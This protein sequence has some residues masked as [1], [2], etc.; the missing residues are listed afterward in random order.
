M[1]SYILPFNADP[2]KGYPDELIN[3]SLQRLTDKEFIRGAKLNTDDKWKLLSIIHRLQGLG[4]G[5]FISMKKALQM[6]TRSNITPESHSIPMTLLDTFV[7][8]AHLGLIRSKVPTGDELGLRFYLGRP[9][10]R[11]EYTVVIVPMKGPIPPAGQPRNR[12][13]E[14]EKRF[15]ASSGVPFFALAS[16]VSATISKSAVDCKQLVTLKDPVHAVYFSDAEFM[17]L[18]DSMKKGKATEMQIYYAIND[19]KQLTTVIIFYDKDG[20]PVVSDAVAALAVAGICFDQGDLIPPPDPVT[21][22]E[23][24]P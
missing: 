10:P 24:E 7:D 3:Q 18:Y 12:L 19:T 14:E 16:A 21:D 15:F 9:S 2:L 20:N 22:S 23:L 13:L 5:G 1:P 17:K 8:N 11:H 6:I 4:D